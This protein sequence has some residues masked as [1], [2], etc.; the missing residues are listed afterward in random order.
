[1][2]NVMSY[3]GLTTKVKAMQAKLLT[4]QDFENIANLH[5]VPEAVEYLKG[6][7]AYAEALGKMDDTLY[8]RGNVEKVLGQSLYADYTRLYRF[9]GMRQ[10]KFMRGFWKRYEIDLINYCLRIVFNHYDVPFDINYKK[11]YF[12]KYS[13]LDVD[14]MIASRNIQEL[15]ESLKDTEYYEPLTPVKDKQDATLYD[16]EILLEQHFFKNAWTKQR[17][18]LDKQEQ[19]IFKRDCGMKIDLLNLNWIYRAKKYYNMLAPDIY[20]MV[21]PIQYR[22]RPDEFKAMVEAPSLEQFLQLLSNSYYEKRFHAMAQSENMEEFYRACI[23]N[24]YMSD[25]RK[26]PYSLATVNTYL[27][28]KEEEIDRLITAL[29]CIR[30]GLTP[31]ETLGYIGGKKE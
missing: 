22:I 18:A 12:D 7:P 17:K 27:F 6:K 24:L 3:S 14:K 30:Y 11:E 31:R 9:A 1:M 16:Y 29:E 21:I 20:L 19:E 10:K 4:D 23:H 25:R 15:V 8:H 28:L 26:N 5:S 13:Q 2:G